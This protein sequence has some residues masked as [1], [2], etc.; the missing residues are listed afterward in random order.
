MKK[1]ASGVSTVLTVA[2]KISGVAGKVA[3]TAGKVEDV[4]QQ[5][6]NITQKRSSHRSRK[7]EI[8][9]SYPDCEPVTLYIASGVITD[10]DGNP[11]PNVTV[12]IDDVTTTSNSV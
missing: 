7:D 2:N 8:P 4:S 3:D 1:V 10:R 11:I 12:Q 6:I 5:V 9:S